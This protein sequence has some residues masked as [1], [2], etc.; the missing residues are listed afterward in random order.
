MPLTLLVSSILTG[1]IF[2]SGD[3]TR[4]D[5][6]FRL[7]VNTHSTA[8][9]PWIFDPKGVKFQVSS[10]NPQVVAK[11]GFARPKPLK[12]VKSDRKGYLAWQAPLALSIR[13]DVSTWI[14]VRAFC[15]NAVH[16]AG[17]NVAKD[18]HVASYEFYQPNLMSDRVGEL[19]SSLVGKR[20]WIFGSVALEKE[21][22]GTDRWNPRL[23]A[24]VIRVER[25][26]REWAYCSTASG[27]AE[28]QTYRPQ[29]FETVQ[30]IRL[31]L[32]TPSPSG[33]SSSGYIE[34]ADAWM[35]PYVLSIQSPDKALQ[36]E[37]NSNCSRFEKGEVEIGMSRELVV[38]ILGYP[39]FRK[40]IGELWSSRRWGYS[41][42]A[43]FFLQIEFDGRNRV[44]TLKYSGDLP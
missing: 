33:H 37:S 32:E 15:K 7:S 18:F 24:K 38:R 12:T 41:G 8:A 5:K 43:P 10:S 39:N 9:R 3:I 14:T 29:A 27:C 35:I 26:A 17:K 25:T 28:A 1:T 34:V 4:S 44:K 19:S 6:G 11:L 42:P 22:Y 40:S 36:L 13:K 2:V 16:N 30:P 23:P 31:W 21:W 20:V